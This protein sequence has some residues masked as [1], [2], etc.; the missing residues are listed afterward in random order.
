[1]MK[2]ILG[3]TML[4]CLLNIAVSYGQENFPAVAIKSTSGRSVDF[5]KLVAETKDTVVIVSFWATWC[6]PCVT[7]LDNISD[8]YKEWQAKLPFKFLAISI[9]DA[10]TSQRVKPF[11]TG[12]GWPFDIYLDVNHDL[13][14]AFNVNDVPYVL[15]IKNNKVVYQHVGYVAGNEEELFEKI[16]AL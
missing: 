8:L 6:V 3:L 15:V 10:R 4:V 12:K 2:K 11:V 1:M 14:R 5:S 16:K 9:D 13:K 7:E